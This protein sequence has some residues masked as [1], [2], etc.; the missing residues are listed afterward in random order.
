MVG[1]SAEMGRDSVGRLSVADGLMV[2]NGWPE[3]PVRGGTVMLRSGIEIEGKEGKLID[4]TLSVGRE[5][6]K[7]MGSDIRLPV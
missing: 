4:G 7:L 2:G 3:T 5:G 6:H 1:R